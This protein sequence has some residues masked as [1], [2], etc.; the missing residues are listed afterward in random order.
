MTDWSVTLV[1][2]MPSGILSLI[3][4]FPHPAPSPD[5]DRSSRH[6]HDAQ[7]QRRFTLVPDQEGCRVFV[8][9]STVATS[10]SCRVLPWATMGFLRISPACQRRHPADKDLRLF[11][12][13]RTGGRQH[14]LAVEGGENI[15][16]RNAQRRQPVMGEGDKDALGLFADNIDLFDP[17]HVPNSLAQRFRIRGPAAAA[18]PLSPS[19]QRARRS[20]R[21]IRH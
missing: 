13:N 18:A 5:P 6:A 12:I 19:A 20:R 14:V 21:R 11:G 3:W 2:V 17:R 7:Q 1:R 4:P 16:R 10:D 9:R 15:L 8:A